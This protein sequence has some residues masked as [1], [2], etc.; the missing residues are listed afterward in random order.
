MSQGT[1]I[2]WADVT[3]NFLAGCE[4]VNELC[5][6]CYAIEVSRWLERMGNEDY[7]GVARKTGAINNWT[8]IDQLPGSAVQVNWKKLRTPPVGPKKEAF[9]FVNSMSDTFHDSVPYEVVDT[10]IEEVVRKRPKAVFM[11]LT[12]RPENMVDWAMAHYISKYGVPLP[13]NCMWGASAGTQDTLDDSLDYLLQM[14]GNK[15]ISAEPLL[16]EMVLP[17]R[18]SEVC[19]IVIGGESGRKARRMMPYHAYDLIKQAQSMS[20][21]VHFKQWG[22]WIELGQMTQFQILQARQMKAQELFTPL[23]EEKKGLGIGHKYYRLGKKNT[24]VDGHA[25]IDGKIIHESPRLV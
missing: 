7:A 21:P 9:I 3:H 5:K 14:P 19:Y 1:T 22:E 4:K 24:L 18:A 10:Y 6:N 16:G 2:S 13:N 17:G 20:I 11:F 12:K 25:Y 8:P 15:W 23:S